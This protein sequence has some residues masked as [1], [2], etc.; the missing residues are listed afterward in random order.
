ML[1]L[2]RTRNTKFRLRS[3]ERDQETDRERLAQLFGAIESARD[4]ALREEEGLRRRY[5]TAQADAAFSLNDAENDVRERRDDRLGELESALVYYEQR[6]REL[7]RQAAA[8]EALLR[9][10]REEL[11]ASGTA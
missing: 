6:I 4:A 1:R 9:H 2:L 8:L 7:K 11:T 5:E 3:K 10:A